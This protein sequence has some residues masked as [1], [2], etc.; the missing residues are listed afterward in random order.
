MNRAYLCRGLYV[1]ALLCAVAIFCVVY[2]LYTNALNIQTYSDT[3]SDSGPQVYSN[4]TFDFVLTT[5]VAPG[6]YIEI[7]PPA[8][9]EITASTTSFAERNIEVLIN[10]VAR[11]SG[12]TLDTNTDEVVITRG[13]PGLIRYNL[14][15]SIGITSGSNVQIK[16]GSHTANA[17]RDSVSF[18]STTGT[19]TTYH[20]IEPIKNSSQIGTHKV[21][22]VIGGGVAEA[23][24]GFSIAVV[25]SVSTGRVDTT[26]LVPPVRFNGEPTGEI[27]GTTL[28]V[29][30]S[31]ETN[32]L[33]RCKYSSAAGTAFFSM[34]RFFT[35]TGQ[36]VHSTIVAVATNTINSYYVRCIDD[37]G[38]FNI[39]DYTISFISLPQP[40]GSPTTGSSTTGNGL[41]TGNAGSGTGGA[42]TG[43]SGSGGGNTGG[44]SSGS[45]GSGGGSG[46]SS[47]PVNT[48]DAGGGFESTNGPY[49]SGDA[50]VIIRGYAYPGSTVNALV[51]GFQSASTRASGD[52]SYSITISA[53]SR[54]VYTFGVY[55]VE[56]GNG[57]KSS[58]FSTSFTV[59]GGRTSNLSNINIMPS[60][61]V[62]PD[63]VTP[64]GALA[65]KGRSIPN[66][67]ITVENQNDKSSGS[68]KTFTA[69]ANSSGDWSL[70][71]DTTGFT[72]GTYKIRAKSKQLAGSLLE[73]NFSD[74]TLYGVGQGADVPLN[75][76]L[77]TDGKV[78][79]TDFS[80]LLFWWG[81]DASS[82]NPPV[83]INRDGKVNLTDFSIL[84]FNWTG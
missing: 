66:A 5:E 2:P 43:S 35:H 51:D 44:S 24:A 83:D 6:G 45:G 76:D 21:N 62:T 10:G 12:A 11:A 16:I 65:V 37:E 54:G 60:V 74:Y 73:T 48:G 28:N 59:T 69:Q 77:N 68:K 63:P 42:G 19:T 22:V 30:M 61:S 20:D 56:G 58:T 38:N 1:A 41:G 32:E 72:K 29:E 34:P 36:L 53:I 17:L 3:I 8:G 71:I 47:G 39:D 50:E 46:G 84:L 52:G 82:T 81:K 31:V 15:P 40:T 18:S 79:L 78:N 55:A 9:F 25:P 75:A 80:I 64:G 4:H 7:E 14:N 49:R 23:Y 26:E 27:G 13:S 70:S 67:E 33:S 57:K